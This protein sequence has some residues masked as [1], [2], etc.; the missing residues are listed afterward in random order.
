MTNE[1]ESS[2]DLRENDIRNQTESL[3]KSANG[4]IAALKTELNDKIDN[5]SAKRKTKTM[6]NGLKRVL[7]RS[8]TRF[9][10][11]HARLV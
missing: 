1:F 5:E 9:K 3:T 4:S 2:L 7:I 6:S 10:G 11:V 8:Y